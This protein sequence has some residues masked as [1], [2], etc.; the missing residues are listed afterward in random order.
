[1]KHL[2]F[3]FCLSFSLVLVLVSCWHT[4]AI[5][6]PEYG[7]AVF[8]IALVLLIVEKKVAQLEQ[9][10]STLQM[11]NNKLKQSEQKNTF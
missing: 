6:Q 7:S 4:N 2:L 8:A 5:E 11:Q 3:R 1:M 9:T 10:I